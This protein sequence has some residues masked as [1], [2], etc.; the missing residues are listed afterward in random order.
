[1]TLIDAAETSKLMCGGVLNVKG[2]IVAAKLSVVLF[3]FDVDV[4]TIEI[5][6]SSF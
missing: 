2:K 3:Q 5:E 1:M 6:G 4:I